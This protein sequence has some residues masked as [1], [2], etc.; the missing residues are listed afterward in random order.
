MSTEKP[1]ILMVDD[2]ANILSGYRR[3]LAA[4]YAVD[5]AAG[6]KAALELMTA[7][8]GFRVITSDMRM[9]EMDGV[10]FCIAAHR[11]DPN[12]VLIMLTG[13][14][15]QD[16]AVRALNEGAVFR[17]LNKP[18][19]PDVLETTIQ[20]ALKKYDQISIERSVLRDTLSGCV[21]MLV[22]AATL[23]DPGAGEIIERIRVNVLLLAKGLHLDDWRLGLAGNLCLVGRLVTDPANDFHSMTEPQLQDCAQ[24]GAA[25]IK[26]IPRLAQ[27]AE[28]VRR[29]RE[30]GPLPAGTDWS[31]ADRVLAAARVVRFAVDFER[32]LRASNHNRAGALELLASSPVQYDRTLHDVARAILLMP[33]PGAFT[34]T[35]GDATTTAKD[36]PVRQLAE[37]MVV[38][39]DVS[40]SEGTP[41][42][43]KGQMLTGAAI[44]QAIELEKSGLLPGM[45][46]VA[47]GSAGSNAAA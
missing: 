4:R 14:A 19:P 25:L 37:G 8:P 40:T 13:N 35:P 9:P 22:Q 20:D 1:R 23:K 16:T 46:K 17:F 10:Q 33:P 28:V 34:L 7:R 6:G 31:T 30:P 3:S 26:L 36:L 12:A 24:R 2:E 21:K 5:T 47:C 42:F 38:Q 18:C 29:Q 11:L 27:V 44:A 39:M 32:T 41:V 45:I 15:D 43:T